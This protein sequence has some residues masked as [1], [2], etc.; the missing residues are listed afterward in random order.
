MYDRRQVGISYITAVKD[1]NGPQASGGP[2]CVKSARAPKAGGVHACN[3]GIS[4]Y[5]GSGRLF[6]K[7]ENV[8]TNFA[9]IMSSFETAL[10]VHNA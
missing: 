7:I 5:A 4:N 1:L 10:L 2:F 9:R 3:T 8:F 6:V